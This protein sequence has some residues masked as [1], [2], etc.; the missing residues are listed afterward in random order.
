MHLEIKLLCCIL[1]RY[2]QSLAHMRCEKEFVC[3]FTTVL[4]RLSSPE[5]LWRSH[6]VIVVAWLHWR[7]VT[8][9]QALLLDA[10]AVARDDS[11][12]IA[13]LVRVTRHRLLC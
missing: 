7:R 4:C 12:A 5:C 11:R 10:D 1:S 8:G 13:R 6:N 2:V 3:A 9:Q